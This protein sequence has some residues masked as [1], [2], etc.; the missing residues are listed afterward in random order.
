MHR[1]GGTKGLYYMKKYVKLITALLLVVLMV[2]PSLAISVAPATYDEY[3]QAKEERDKLLSQNSSLTDKLEGMNGELGDMYDSLKENEDLT[4]SIILKEQSYSALLKSC[5]EQY[6]T[7]QELLNVTNE[8]MASINDEIVSLEAKQKKLEESLKTTV[9][10]MHENGSVAYIEFLLGST[11]IVD[12][13]NR[14]EYVSSIVEYHKNLLD[15]VEYNNDLLESRYNELETLRATQQDTVYLLESRR[16][17]YDAIIAECMAELESLGAES[18]VLKEFI[19]LKEEDLGKVEEEIA[20]TIAQLGSIED[21][22][23]DIEDN[24]FFWPSKDTSL[25]NS[26]YG[27]RYLEGKRNLHKGIDIN[28]RYVPVYAA[29]AGVVAE[30]KY[31]SSYGYYIVIAHSNGVE[32]W[33]AHLNSMEVKVG[34][35]VQPHQRIGVS[36]N[37]G[38]STGPHLHF[39]IRVYGSPVNPL[40]YPSLGIYNKYSYFLCP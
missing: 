32:T 35:V 9:R 22:I 2:I 6:R 13:L 36:G 15:E 33:Y 37:S 28:C 26:T 14:L 19:S 24:A 12:F 20:D 7:E 17:E 29:R 30:A 40:Y 8:M 1:P 4:T 18:E 34:D 16:A 3:L 38:W 39:E 31:S 5:M 11:S 23:K 21:K 25:V 27:Y 10:D